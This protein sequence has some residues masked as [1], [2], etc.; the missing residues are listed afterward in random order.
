VFYQR[1]AL[2]EDLLGVDLADGATVTA[3]HAALFG[4]RSTSAPGGALG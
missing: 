3:L 1:V 2:I 4:L